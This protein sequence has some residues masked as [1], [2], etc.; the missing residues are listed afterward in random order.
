MMNKATGR[1]F[2]K[3]AFPFSVSWTAGYIFLLKA[4]STPLFLTLRC[5]QGSL[6][7]ALNLRASTACFSCSCFKLINITPLSPKT[8]R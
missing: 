8:N 7:I 5:L 3:R 4:I 2:G 6:G 1:V